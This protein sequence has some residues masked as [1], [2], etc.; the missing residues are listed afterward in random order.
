MGKRYLLRFLGCHA[1]AAV[2]PFTAWLPSAATEAMIEAIAKDTL[3]GVKYFAAWY[4]IQTF[5]LRLN[6][7]NWYNLST[8][9]HPTKRSD[10]AL[11]SEAAWR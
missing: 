4:F 3:R 8:L 9:N 5:I 2:L 1:I 10:E 7:D 11:P 6:M